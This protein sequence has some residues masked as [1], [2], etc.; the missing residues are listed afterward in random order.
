MKQNWSE[1]IQKWSQY[2]SRSNFILPTYP[3]A[4][5]CSSLPPLYVAQKALMKTFNVSR[6]VGK[7]I[8]LL[9]FWDHWPQ[10]RLTLS[11]FFL[12]LFQIL[13][14]MFF[15]IL[16]SQYDIMLYLLTPFLNSSSVIYLWLL[17]QYVSST[18]VNI[19]RLIKYNTYFF[20][21]VYNIFYVN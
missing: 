6:N 7:I 10:T 16:L 3:V 2:Y 18:S 15:M 9:K 20:I 11:Q 19:I 5:Y 14:I 17:Y 1:L 8:I 13:V 12:F 4:L 21:G